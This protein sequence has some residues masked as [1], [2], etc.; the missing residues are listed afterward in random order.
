MAGWLSMGRFAFRPHGL[1]RVPGEEVV[2]DLIQNFAC[3]PQEGG[4]A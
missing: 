4:V 3:R 1:K 2:K